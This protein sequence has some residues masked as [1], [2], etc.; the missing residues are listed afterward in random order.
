MGRSLHHA[1]DPTEP[2]CVDLV[3]ALQQPDE[4][5]EDPPDFG[6]VGTPL[7]V[8][9]LPHR[10]RGLREGVLDLAQAAVAGRPVQTSDGCQ[11]RRR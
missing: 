9:S 6:G 5:P 3:A 11:G 4:P 10:D 1:H 2:R 8:I 7:A